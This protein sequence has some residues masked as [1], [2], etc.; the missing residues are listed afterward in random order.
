MR[1]QL[2][3][4]E[5]VINSG[6]RTVLYDGDADY[7]C[8]YIGVESMVRSSFFLVPHPRRASS[9]LCHDPVDAWIDFLFEHEV[10]GTVRGTGIRDVQC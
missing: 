7:I 6:V 2:S 9:N 10:F 1:S 5:M 8:N 3:N 4:L